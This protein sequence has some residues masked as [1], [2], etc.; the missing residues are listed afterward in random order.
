M[1][2]IRVFVSSPGDVN[3]ERQL[4]LR[5]MERV[6]LEAEFWGK[7]RFE[8]VAWDAPGKDVPMRATLT[9]QEAVNRGMPMPSQCD[10]VACILWSRLGTPLPP[11]YTRPEDGSP[12]LS[13]TEFEYDDAL[14]AHREKQKPDILVYRREQEITLKP[15]DPAL[16]EKIEQWERVK[17]FFSRFSTEKG[18]LIGGVN[19]YESPSHFSEK[20]ENHL[21]Q[22]ARELLTAEAGGAEF[23]V[24]PVQKPFW[25]GSPFRGLQPFETEHALLFY[26]RDRALD[27]LIAAIAE[28]DENP[29]A[30]RFLA[31]TGVTGSGKSSLVAA[32]LLPRLARGAV[33]GSEDWAVARMRPGDDREGDGC[34]SLADGLLASLPALKGGA[35]GDRTTLARAF[36]ETPEEAGSVLEAGLSDRKGWSK[37]LLVTDQF[38]ELFTRVSPERRLPFVLSLSGLASSGRAVVLATL[39]ADFFHACL[40]LPELADLLNAGGT[41]S[42]PEPTAS[43]L[44]QMIT[45]P[46]PLAGVRFE[47][48]LDG[49]VLDAALA[50]PGALPLLEYALDLLYH[51]RTAEGLMTHASYESFGGVEGSIGRRAE[52]VYRQLPSDAQG[53]LPEVF[54]SLTAMRGEGEAMRRRAEYGH[55]TRSEGARKLVEGF[56]APDVRLLV[57]GTDA[58]GSRTLEVAH[59]ALFSSWGTLSRWIEANKDL[60]HS[61]AR[62][63]SA[64]RDWSSSGGDPAFLFSEGKPLAEAQSLLEA[65]HLD[66]DDVERSFIAASVARS[67]RR[68]RIKRMAVSSLALLALVAVV[69]AVFAN[70][71]RREAR[72]K[73][74]EAVAAREAETEQRKLAE[75]RKKEMEMQAREARAEACYLKAMRESAE[76]NTMSEFA[77]LAGSIRNSPKS[78]YAERLRNIKAVIPEIEWCSPSM[79]DN[80]NSVYS[81]SFSPDGSLI[82]SSSEEPGNIFIWDTLSGNIVT[83]LEHP[84]VQSVSFSPKGNKIAS[85]ALEIII[86]DSESGKEVM[87]T[88]RLGSSITSIDFSPDGNRIASAS[89]DDSIRIWDVQTG[90]LLVFIK[91]HENWSDNYIDIDKSINSVSFSPDGQHIASGSVDNRVRIWDAFSGMERLEI[92]AHS[93][94]NCIDYSPKGENIASASCD[95]FIRIWDAYSGVLVSDLRKHN[96]SALSVAFSPDGKRI[97]SGSSDNTIRI[98]DIQSENEIM[99]MECNGGEIFSVIFNPIGN[100]LVSGSKNNKVKVWRLTCEMERFPGHTRG[101]SDISYSPLGNMVATGASDNKICL[102]DS[103]TGKEI[104]NI[105]TQYEVNSIDMSKDGSR[106]AAGGESG[107]IAIFDVKSGKEQVAFSRS[108]FSVNS[109]AFS[110]NDKYI[111]SGHEWGEINIWDAKSGCL[112]TVL[113]ES[114]EN[115]INSIKYF[116]DGKRIVYGSDDNT[117]CIWDIISKNEVAKLRGH[118]E[119]VTGVAISPNEERVAS[120]SLDKTLRIWDIDR[121]KEVFVLKG[122]EYGINDVEYS[123]N[124]KIVA[125]GSIDNTIRIWSAISGKEIIQIEE[126]TNDDIIAFSP[127][128]KKIAAGSIDSMIRVYDASTGKK[129]FQMEGCPAAINTISLSPNEKDIAFDTRYGNIYIWDIVSGNEEVLISEI[130]NDI[131]SLMFNQDGK[132]IACIGFDVNENGEEALIWDAQTGRFLRKIKGDKGIN[133]VKDWKVLEIR[134]FREFVGKWEVPYWIA[135]RRQ[136]L[137]GKGEL[138][139]E[140]DDILSKWERDIGIRVKPGTTELE[141]IPTPGPAYADNPEIAEKC[142]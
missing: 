94:V 68:T 91:G 32:G 24:E 64:A 122:H 114:S 135:W 129:L 126:Y 56:S 11:R 63:S 22:L 86:W 77:Y 67:R 98:W 33:P 138:V 37:L 111:A 141:R 28:K 31:V 27:D 6:A 17:T 21:R 35:W 30:V 7:V 20:F 123:P 113:R 76:G 48:G 104:T 54:S 12:Y 72:Q 120:G 15:G 65:P 112:R 40:E 55:V 47:E 88:V 80:N 50:Q 39:R 59:E 41:Y 117:V 62:V 103:R 44:S 130:P 53:A 61:R 140:L 105:V 109:I 137:S 81:V 108:P 3:D 128:G 136:I 85:G 49:R 82:A 96:D 10:V 107:S 25:E 18:A 60:L 46:A 131:E 16:E 124:G 70:E 93:S 45:R 73:E 38:E 100:L 90:E 142:K 13:G 36:R 57:P 121:R 95:G 4:A 119:A 116:S 110:P 83:Q 132:K 23:P 134:T 74:A 52:E 71:Q 26:G 2:R 97:S 87:R 133:A 99:R 14:R 58:S 92:D 29:K 102:W 115:S 101:I 127:D 125:S 89:I 34:A 8:P 118:R 1:L 69:A 51:R 79:N 42:L 5:A 84:F 19:L 66:L 43:D 78:T 9:P 139:P 75:K 106:I